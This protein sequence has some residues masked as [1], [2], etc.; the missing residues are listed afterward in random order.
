MWKKNLAA[1]VL[2]G[3]VATAAGQERI[4]YRTGPLWL[5]GF[6]H[7]LDLDE[8]GTA[9]YLFEGYRLVPLPSP[10]FPT[11]AA[12]PIVDTFHFNR[13]DYLMGTDGNILLKQAGYV[14]GPETAPG[15]A[16]GRN[17]FSGQFVS[18]G[19]SDQW[20]GFSGKPAECFVGVRFLSGGQQHYGWVHLLV[21]T[22]QS[23]RSAQ[24]VFPI[25]ADWAYETR[26]DAPIR[27]GAVGSNDGPHWFTVDFRNPDGT[28]HGYSDSFL[29][30]RR[31]TGALVLA[32]DTLR[33]ELTL[34]GVFLA[35]DLRGPAPLHA[36][37]KP[38]SGLGQP[39]F[40][41]PGFSIFAGERKLS[42]SQTIQL[43]RGTYYL[44]LDDGQISGQIVRVNE[45][46]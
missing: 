32:G 13:N 10:G 25:V 11:P 12:T 40:A 16:W 15:E 2:A 22:V 41:L 44:S 23:N 34:A 28:L 6:Y 26:P 8:D 45:G 18:F 24:A 19:Y 35:A 1:A 4:V 37:A 42:R 17:D 27:G 21:P 3:W 31:S 7:L 20:A 38:V 14:F 36:Q 5:D 39:L 43:M 46:D 33:Y 29:G 30:G 9:D